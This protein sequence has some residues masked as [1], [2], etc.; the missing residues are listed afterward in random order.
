MSLDGCSLEPWNSGTET[1]T[2][3][4]AV[5]DP[6]G[7]A[8]HLNVQLIDETDDELFSEDNFPVA[9]PIVF[10]TLP[11]NDG[12]A[13]HAVVRLVMPDTTIVGTCVTDTQ[14]QSS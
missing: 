7:L 6:C 9:G 10:G 11:E 12:H 2:V 5:T 1:F 14:P 13:F 8:D 3:V 4:A